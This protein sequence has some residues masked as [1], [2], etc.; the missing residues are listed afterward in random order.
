MQTQTAAAAGATAAILN[1]Q[2]GDRPADRPNAAPAEIPRRR[3]EDVR[4]MLS[5][6]R[7]PANNAV[8]GSA[9]PVT[10]Y[11]AEEKTAIKSRVDNAR[12]TQL[13]LSIENDRQLELP[14]SS[15]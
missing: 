3:R 9:H 7:L 14:R 12:F 10:N 11:F 15:K 13:F 6:R 4:R 8:H 1:G 2:T 5:R